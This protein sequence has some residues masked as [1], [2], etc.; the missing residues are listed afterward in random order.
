[1]SKRK[2]QTTSPTHFEGIEIKLGVPI[3]TSLVVGNMVGSGIFLLPATMAS[4]G[5]YVFIPWFIACAVALGLALMFARLSRRRPGAGGPIS[6]TFFSFGR[7]VGGVVAWSYWLAVVIGNS[8]VAYTF[9]YYIG[10]FFPKLSGGVAVPIISITIIWFL[11][12]LNARTATGAARLQLVSAVLKI[13]PL[14]IL[15]VFALPQVDSSL[16][17]P[18]PQPLNLFSILPMAGLLIWAFIGFESAT[19]PADITDQPEK[20]IPRATILGTSFVCVLY[21]LI[22]LATVGTV[23]TDMLADSSVPLVLVA[24]KTIGAGGQM[25]VTLAGILCMLASLNGFILISGYLARAAA[26]NGFFPHRLG[27]LSGAGNT[28]RHAF[29]AGAI[30]ATLII[31]LSTRNMF[32]NGFVLLTA[33]ATTAMFIP[34][35]LSCAA[36]V[37]SSWREKESGVPVCIAVSLLAILILCF[38]VFAIMMAKNYIYFAVWIVFMMVLGILSGKLKKV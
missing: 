37:L 9:A 5:S 1:M 17:A 32:L 8:A 3:C 12:L 28:P 21:L 22:M 23:P 7:Y 26:L 16:L 19:I 4:L 15:L 27:L 6:Y 2:L 11:T 38:L 30:I 36:E 14:L 31:L 29:F 34:Y 24:S 25:V 33:L 20:T 18:P 35:I 13:I 10:E